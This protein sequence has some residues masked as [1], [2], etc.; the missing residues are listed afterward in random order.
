[1]DQSFW[2][3]SITRA[4]LCLP[5]L[6]LSRCSATHCISSQISGCAPRHLHLLASKGYI[7]ASSISVCCKYSSL[8]TRFATSTIV[9]SE[10][11]PLTPNK[12]PQPPNTLESQNTPSSLEIYIDDPTSLQASLPMP[13][14]NLV[15]PRDLLLELSI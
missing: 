8:C 11:S 14:P 10:S 12:E 15:G 13:N 4:T 3:A 7:V 6:T 9:L 5:P 2:I 1:M